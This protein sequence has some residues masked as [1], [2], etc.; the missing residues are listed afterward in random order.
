MK[1]II[2]VGI[3][4]G[5]FLLIGISVNMFIEGEDGRGLVMSTVTKAANT[6]GIGS[7]GASQVLKPTTDFVDYEEVVVKYNVTE[8]VCV[9]N[10]PTENGTARCKTFGKT[11]VEKT[12]VERVKNGNVVIRGVLIP[13]GEDEWGVYVGD[14]RVDFV[15]V[16]GGL[17]KNN[18]E[19]FSGCQV[20]GGMN[21]RTLIFKNTKDYDEYMLNSEK[22]SIETSKKVVRR[23]K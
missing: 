5:A 1:R 15:K 18:P 9:D 2:L 3:I 17:D 23:L 8:L 10:T 21:C 4:A 7:Q 11:L 20:E 19:S 22:F 16:N 6:L 13:K 14:G 12:R